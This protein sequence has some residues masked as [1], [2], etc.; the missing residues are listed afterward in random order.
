MLAMFSWSRVLLID[1]SQGV[2]AAPID[3]QYYG[4]NSSDYTIYSEYN[5]N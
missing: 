2:P 1:D 5:D 3:T 4:E